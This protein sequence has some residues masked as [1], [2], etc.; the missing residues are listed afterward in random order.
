MSI[1]T[2]SN[3]VQG[4]DSVTGKERWFIHYGPSFSNVPTPLSNRY[5]QLEAA[6]LLPDEMQQ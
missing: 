5:L 3:R 4:L 6:K 1:S 2:A